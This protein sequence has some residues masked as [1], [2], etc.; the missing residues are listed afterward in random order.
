MELESLS[1]SVSRVAVV[2]DLCAIV[3]LGFVL[4]SVLGEEIS[5]EQKFSWENTS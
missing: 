1:S 5:W 4:E 2:G 3:F